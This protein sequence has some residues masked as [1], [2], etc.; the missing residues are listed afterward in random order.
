MLENLSLTR[1][2]A[3]YR[4]REPLQLP[5]FTGAA[6]RG[7]L[8]YAL[9][10]VR[11]GSTKDCPGCSIRSECRYGDLYAY[12][13]ES[14]WDH[15]LIEPFHAALGPR[16]RRETY[17]Q[18]FILNPPAGGVEQLPGSLFTVD[19]ILVGRAIACF[20]FMA[21]ALSI[22]GV[23]GIGKGRSRILLESIVNGFPSNGGNE[24]VI[25]DAKSG[26]IVGPGEI[27]DLEIVHRWV[28]ES[29]PTQGKIREVKIHFI[30]PFR[31]KYD[32]KLG[33]PLTFEI[34]MRNIFRRFTLLSVH[35]RLTTAIDYKRLLSLAASVQVKSSTLRWYRVERY[36]T[37]Q[38]SYMNL[39]GYVGEITFSGDM[40]PFLPYLKMGEFLNVGKDASF[41][42]GKY[43]MSLIPVPVR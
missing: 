2:R 14:P 33:Q 15:P 42:L 43:Y 38:E 32:G 6:L 11:Y 34:F 35:S 10:Q 20:P 36:S 7:A 16:M 21:C 40:A 18:P 26:Q 4:I 12:L 3:R 1:L 22:A 17:P 23:S 28:E 8:G 41:G 30:T 29:A 24:S 19:F 5:T 37:R 13:F 9:R 27:I 25:F 39:D 31:Y